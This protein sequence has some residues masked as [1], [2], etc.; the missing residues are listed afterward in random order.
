MKFVIPIKTVSTANERGIGWRAK[1]K[2][3][4]SEREAT[5]VVFRGARVK[6]AV[7][8]FPLAVLLTRV[9][10]GELDSDNLPPSMKAIRDQLAEELRL[11][12]DRDPRVTWHYAQARE[13]GFEVRVEITPEK[14]VQTSAQNV[15]RG[16]PSG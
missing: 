12:S 4:R 1:A 3:V 5:S 2:R 14:L 9:S 15:S 16:A 13:R 6:Q 10:P 11:P 7:P 8:D